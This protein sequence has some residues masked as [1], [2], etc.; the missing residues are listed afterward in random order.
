MQRPTPAPADAL[1]ALRAEVPLTQ[2]LTNY[3]AMNIAAN[4]L[5]AAGAAP[6]MVHTPEESGDFARIA[7]AVTINIGTLS[8]LWV[9][10]M[11]AAATA[12]NDVGTPWVFD[13]VAHFASSYRASAAR[14]LLALR[15]T[16]LRGNASEILALA[17]G[18]TSARGVDATDPVMA[19]EP[20]ARQ[21]AHQT[22]GVVVV[23][24]AVDLVTDGTRVATVAGGS[25]LM[26]QVTAL[27]CSLTCL[28]GSYA[29]VAAPF[30]AALGALVLFAEAGERAARLAEG[31]GSFGWR[32]LDALAAVTPADLTATERVTWG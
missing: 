9:E 27:G 3:V 31:P 29:A 32:F 21:L 16:I 7:R 6:A 4:V 17:G 26:P 10:G 15:P 2:C 30:E 25:P 18:D 19:A 20:A 11:R 23:T 1:R 12:A 13:P 8:P 24:G 14:D 28:M 22:G 5:L